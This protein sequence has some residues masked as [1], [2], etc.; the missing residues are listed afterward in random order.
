MSITLLLMPSPKCVVRSDPIAVRHDSHVQPLGA[1]AKSAAY[2]N[3]A[4][5]SHR[6]MNRDRRIDA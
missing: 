2:T 4:R 6:R 1:S 3:A 5:K